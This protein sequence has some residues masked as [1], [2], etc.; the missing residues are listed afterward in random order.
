MAYGSRSTT[1]KFLVG[2]I[3][4]H[5]PTN[6]LPTNRDVLKYL[7]FKKNE[8]LKETKWSPELKVLISCTIVTHEAGALCS[9]EGGC[10]SGY[11]CVVKAI[12]EPWR[13]AGIQ[14]SQDRWIM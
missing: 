1:D 4:D 5:I 8:A 2:Q 12:K 14:S 11:P 3:K 13:L 7:F 6:Q 10:H 9:A